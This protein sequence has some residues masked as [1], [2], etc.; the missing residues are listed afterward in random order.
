MFLIK[1]CIKDRNYEVAVKIFISYDAANLKSVVKFYVPTW[2][3]FSYY[4]DIESLVIMIM[5][6]SNINS[7]IIIVSFPVIIIIINGKYFIKYIT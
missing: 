1:L 4:P 7:S 3:Q 2:P 5:I 6:N